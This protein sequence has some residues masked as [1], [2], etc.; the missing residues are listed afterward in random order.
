MRFVSWQCTVHAKAG[1]GGSRSIALVE[2]SVLRVPGELIVGLA[3]TRGYG[4]GIR[5]SYD[6]QAIKMMLGGR[7]NS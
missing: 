5:G 2:S 1:S 6:R 3:G 4:C 7:G